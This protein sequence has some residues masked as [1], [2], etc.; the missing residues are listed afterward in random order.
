M[1]MYVNKGKYHSLH[2][3]RFFNRLQESNISKAF[4]CF[5]G[6]NKQIKSMMY[7]HGEFHLLDIMTCKIVKMTPDAAYDA[8]VKMNTGEYTVRTHGQ[9][10]AYDTPCKKCGE[11]SC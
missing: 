11:V 6:E 1:L 10:N 3:I 2:V 5:K 9:M 8:L 4:I 7:E